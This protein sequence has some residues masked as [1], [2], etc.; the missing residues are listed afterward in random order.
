MLNRSEWS[1]RGSW[2][3]HFR[4]PNVIFRTRSAN[5]SHTYLATGLRQLQ[6]FRLRLILLHFI[7]GSE[8]TD[9]VL[10]LLNDIDMELFYIAN[11]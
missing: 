11:E 1:E 10:N 4:P 3:A 5:V 2:N 6:I 7:E 9:G 8:F